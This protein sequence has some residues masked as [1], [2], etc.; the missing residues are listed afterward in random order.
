MFITVYMPELQAD[1][2][3]EGYLMKKLCLIIMF[4][5][6]VNLISFINPVP[7]AKVMAEGNYLGSKENPLT[8]GENT[9]AV[10]EAENMPVGDNTNYKVVDDPEAS[11]KKGVRLDKYITANG[12]LG[13]AFVPSE[14]IEY[15]LYTKLPENVSQFSVWIRFKSTVDTDSIAY[16]LNDM[17]STYMSLGERAG[18]LNQYNWASLMVKVNELERINI[19]FR[20]SSVVDKIVVSTDLLY[21]PSGMGDTYT[22]FSLGVDTTNYENLL[23]PLP[24]YTPTSERPR[25]MFNREM[26]NE[27]KEKMIYPEHQKRFEELLKL[28]DGNPENFNT[29]TDYMQYCDSNAFLYLWDG[30]KENGRK[31][32]EVLIM[33][34][35]RYSEDSKNDRTSIAAH[36]EMGYYIHYAARVYDWCYDLMN[37]QEKFEIIKRIL[38]FSSCQE[39]GFPPTLQTGFSNAHD[40]ENQIFR[41]MLAFAIATYED[42]PEYYN[43]IAGKFFYEM[44]PMRNYLYEDSS[45]PVTGSEY[46]MSRMHYE[47][48]LSQLL[49][50]AGLGGLLGS[51]YKFGYNTI[52]DTRPDGF[53]G[54]IGDSWAR[55]AT[56]A[57]AGTAVSLFYIAN[58]Y[59]DPYLR[60]MYFNDTSISLPDCSDYLVLDD[61]SIG[62]RDIAELP[63]TYF[64]GKK[65][66]VM[67]ARTGWEQGN[68]SKDMWV[69]MTAPEMMVGGHGHLDSGNFTIYYKG[70]LACDS[71]IYNGLAFADENGNYVTNTES[72][73]LHDVNYHHRTVA[74]NCML[75]HDPSETDVPDGGQ[76][77]FNPF[78]VSVDHLIQNSKAGKILGYEYGEDIN[79]PSYSY[80][81][82]DIKD[83]YSDKVKEY[84][85]S[86]MFLNFFDEV[87]PGALIV[88]DK[89]TSKDPSFEKDW[90]LHFNSDNEPKVEG[91][92]VTT[93]KTTYGDNGRLINDTLLPKEGNFKIETIGGKGK[94]FYSH[95]KNW[96]AVTYRTNADQGNWRIELTPTKASNTDYF[97]NVM[98]VGDAGLN[99]EPLN[100]ELLETNQYYGVKI[101]DRVAFFGK[102]DKRIEDDIEISAFGNDEK[103]LFMIADVKEGLWTLYKDGIKVSDIEVTVEGGVAHF[104]GAPGTYKL[105]RNLRVPANF[106]KNYNILD[107]LRKTDEEYFYLR[108]NNRSA[109]VDGKLIDEN[110]KIYL[111]M[112]DHIE[113]LGGYYERIG[114]TV[115]VFASELSYK[116]IK[117]G[118]SD[119][120]ETDGILYIDIEAIKD[121]LNYKI[122]KSKYEYG[123]TLNFTGG[124]VKADIFDHELPGIAK[125]KD[126][127]GLDYET[128]TSP[129]YAVDGDDGTL[130][131]TNKVGSY[132]QVEFEKPETFKGIEVIWAVER[133]HLIFIEV[134]TDG[135][136]YEKVFEDWVDMRKLTTGAKYST[137]DMFNI[138][139]V[140]FVRFGVKENSTNGVW[141]N[142]R[143]VRFLVEE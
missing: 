8:V 83:A 31:A 55:P 50:A 65:S 138:E 10:F 64:T 38:Y 36:R 80:L 53:S 107:N 101:K 88:Y 45:L 133:K 25:V 1:I 122:D 124:I 4:V 110:G 95:G 68:D 125:L 119:T 134:S 48:F 104:E 99:P 28:A 29:P 136:N 86:F 2:S 40:S 43:M 128:D 75:V 91:N 94:E 58:Y 35:G 41:D 78:G 37:E 121:V 123:K 47:V 72:G 79:T 57:I 131:K 111:P 98:Q 90:L 137:Y 139:G 117:L 23:W 100:P 116:D 56:R 67:Y 12:V 16:S 132:L 39:M 84:T 34:L 81:K 17:D 26:I 129:A 142:M 60:Q 93:T 85:R 96:T 6:A 73:S 118:G 61:P 143:D 22:P 62:I 59:R 69:T 11:G 46:G 112:F 7:V 44:L 42:Y 82:G 5:F 18:T 130:W 32:I 52:Y 63:K 108:V 97:L 74:H 103:L 19:V 127:G 20:S 141:G 24:P 27:A 21:F 106:S 51:Q 113:N 135:K 76:K 30:N 126:V 115:R 33:G 109:H 66:G 70:Y 105:V 87:Y 140:K 3:M 114:D 92:R 120:K 9:I 13:Y 15:S 54:R 71:G 77:N 89:I 14:Q 102:E 49:R